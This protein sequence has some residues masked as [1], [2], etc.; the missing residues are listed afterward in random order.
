MPE[1]R[2]LQR[3]LESIQALRE[4][5]QAMRN[6]AAV[7]VRRAE[8]TLRGTRPYSEIVQTA[9]ATV[10]R[11]LQTTEENPAHAQRP[12]LAIVFGSD[13][14]LCG[15]YNEKVVNRTTDFL[16]EHPETPILVV[17]L[18]AA[19][20]I[21]QKG[22]APALVLEA[23]TSLAGIKAKVP[24]LAERAFTEV[25]E[26]GAEE[27]Y[28][29]YNLYV[30][31]GQYEET[32]RRVLPP[33]KDD[34]A[35]AME[36]PFRGDPILT[37]TPQAL[38]GHLIE[39]YFFVQLFRVLLESHASENGARL[40]AMTAASSNIDKRIGDLTKEYQTVRQDVVTA[41]LLD[42]VGGAEALR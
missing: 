42:V 21:K 11:R 10:L 29:I 31:M 40:L 4:I 2:E 27:L 38:L 15:T 19:G 17:G 33:S 9:L 28:F 32:V 26:A 30:S 34:L 20:V 25:T 12:A 24:D 41:E 6:L 1:L 13:Q 22:I 37:D 39:E 8:T 18:R 7:Y 16:S 23:P 5:V 14:G 3:K 36:L 35:E